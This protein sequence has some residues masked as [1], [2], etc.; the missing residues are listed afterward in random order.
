MVYVEKQPVHGNV[1]EII[2]TYY[3]IYIHVHVHVHVLCIHAYELHVH[4]NHCSILVELET[5]EG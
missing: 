3:I 4:V 5:F 1:F 2:Y